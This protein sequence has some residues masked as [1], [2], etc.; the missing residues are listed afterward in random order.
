M[1]KDAIGLPGAHSCGASLV[2][3]STLYLGLAV[4]ALSLLRRPAVTAIAVR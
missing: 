2:S 3:A 1:T 4:V